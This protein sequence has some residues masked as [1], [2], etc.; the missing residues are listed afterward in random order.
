MAIEASVAAIKHAYQFFEWSSVETYMNDDN[1][2]ARKLV[3]KLGGLKV[4]RETFPDG[5]PRNIYRFP[6]A[7]QKG[8][9]ES[10]SI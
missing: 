6:E 2:A 5:L 10:L 8:M 9:N 3:E 7:L 4:T 1:I